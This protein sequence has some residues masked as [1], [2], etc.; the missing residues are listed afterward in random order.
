MSINF[1]APTGAKILE[2]GGGERPSPVTTCNMDIRP[3]PTVHIVHDL[4]QMPWPLQDAE[5]D[6]VVAQY[7]LEHVSWRTVPAVLAEIHRVLKPGGKLALVLPNTEAQLKWIQT[8]QEGWDGRDL[9]SSAGGVLFG[10]QDYSANAHRSYWSPDIAIKLLAAAGFE[11]VQTVPAGARSTDMAVEATKPALPVPVQAAPVEEAPQEQPA[12]ETPADHAPLDTSEQ[13][14]SAFDSK[15]FG[16][17]SKWGGYAHEGLADFPVHN[18]TARYVQTRRPSSILELGAARGYLGKRW[19][20][21]GIG[22]RGLEIS[23]HCVMTRVSAGVEW[24]DACEGVWPAG[25]KEYDLSFSC[26][27]MEHIPEKYLPNVISEMARTCRR[28]L[29]GIDLGAH[30]DGFDKTHCTLR[31]K[32]WW[33]AKFAELAPGW[34]VEVVD[35]EELEALPPGGF[36]KD[37][38]QG[39]GKLKLNVGSFTTMF[40]HGW[41]NLDQHDL[42][43][44]AAQRGYQFKHC[45]V[46]G[47]LPFMTGSVD[48]IFAHHSLEHLTY[49][50]GK[51]LLREF[52]R[53]L[54][55]DGALRI[56][57]PNAELLVQGYGEGCGWDTLTPDNDFAA[58]PHLVDYGEMNEGAANADSDVE[59]LY[60]LLCAGHAALYDSYALTKA[61][62]KAGFEVEPTK[63]RRAGRE[64]PGTQ[65][66]LRET[67]E[68][69]YNGSSLLVDAWP[70]STVTV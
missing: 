67:T 33:L 58:A 36:P 34:P 18:I 45:D 20:D 15:Y 41:L 69:D 9:F 35:K 10:D 5:W 6:A 11:D 16:G 61:L 55:P 42:S 48:L 2:L 63:F 56:A 13:R 29:H 66:I 19:E 1:V 70:S 28:G 47:G 12:Q 24:L 64:H 40:Q 31:P 27:V 8:H 60:A 22:Y 14:Q 23:R 30:D 39:D 38:L 26:A 17:G 21:A 4:E 53:V 50:E 62:E 49:H 32:S 43:Q 7:I 44:W 51:S 37:V 57:V 59:R 68:M 52:R 25:D 3:G 65:Q 46:R 54:K